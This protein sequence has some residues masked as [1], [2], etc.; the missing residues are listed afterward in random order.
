MKQLALIAVFAALIMKWPAAAQDQQ[1]FERPE[2]PY[3]VWITL[4]NDLNLY[5][6]EV[7]GINDTA[8]TVSLLE[9]GAETRFFYR[10]ID[11]IQ[12]RGK[13]KL[14]RGVGIGA[15]VGFTIGATAAI[16][17]GRKK[18]QEESDDPL[19]EVSLLGL[20]MMKDVPIWGLAG[21]AV[22]A[23]TGA[24]IGST[25]RK[26]EIGGQKDRF[27]TFRIEIQGVRVH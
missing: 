6:G 21:V 13:K 2:K 4:K 5:H 20:N 16:I 22:G 25:R 26:Y 9:S 17:H 18:A 12:G 7:S 8:M 15:A 24:I 14:K 11:L 27:Q 23:G 10:D 19:S 3:L 1:A